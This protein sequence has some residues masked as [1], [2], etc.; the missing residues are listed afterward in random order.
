MD[1]TNNKHRRDNS[2]SSTTTAQEY[3]WRDYRIDKNHSEK[4]VNTDGDIRT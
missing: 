3:L 2:S 1:E 4:P